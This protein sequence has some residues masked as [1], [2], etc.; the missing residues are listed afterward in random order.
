MLFILINKF[1]YQQLSTRFVIRTPRSG[2]VWPTLGGDCETTGGGTNRG[3][4]IGHGPPAA[5][6][7]PPAPRT[8]GSDGPRPRAS[9]A[10]DTA[11]RGHLR[12]GEEDRRTLPKD[13]GTDP[14]LLELGDP[15]A[16]HLDIGT[17]PRLLGAE[18]HQTMVQGT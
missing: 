2:S 1:C 5:T 11:T 14:P 6:E 16:L 18:G 3:R 10:V 17:D 15:R 13:T 12:Q 7:A 4:G 8:P 9:V